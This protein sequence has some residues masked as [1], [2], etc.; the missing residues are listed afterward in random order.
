MDCKG[1]LDLSAE[2]ASI[3][4]SFTKKNCTMCP[5]QV[6]LDGKTES[7]EEIATR[8]KCIENLCHQLYLSYIVP[9]L[10][11]NLCSQSTFPLCELCLETLKSFRMRKS[12]LE[13]LFQSKHEEFADWIFN[14]ARECLVADLIATA[15]LEPSSEVLAIGGFDAGSV[16]PTNLTLMLLRNAITSDADPDLMQNTMMSYQAGP[17]Q[18][19]TSSVQSDF[20]LR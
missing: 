1:P 6:A 14:K 15:A 18:T 8:K 16:L 4:T 10:N 3:S 11:T 12:T 20:H 19:T 2:V 5:D 17:E 7:P 9:L 13:N